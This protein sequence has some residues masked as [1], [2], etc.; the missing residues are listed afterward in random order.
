MPQVQSCRRDWRRAGVPVC[1]SGLTSQAFVRPSIQNTPC[2]R[3]KRELQ[4]ER[5]R[6]CKNPH[7]S[8]RAL[9]YQLPTTKHP[10]TVPL[11]C[12]RPQIVPNA[13]LLHNTPFR[14]S[15]KRALKKVLVCCERKVFQKHIERTKYHR[16]TSLLFCR[17]LL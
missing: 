13:G 12:R 3:K 11:H 6:L 8:K 5:F 14:L 17:K 10:T 4:I 2:L 9:E 7:R 15:N 16:Q 1:A